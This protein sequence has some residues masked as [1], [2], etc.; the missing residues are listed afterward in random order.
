ML[1]QLFYRAEPARD[2]EPRLDELWNRVRTSYP[3]A[4]VRDADRALR[5]FAAHPSIRY[6][7]FLVCPRFSSRAVASAVF[8]LE[9]DCLRWVDVVWDHGHPGALNLLAFISGRLV[10]QIGA[11]HEELWLAGD[12]EAHPLLANVGFSQSTSSAPPFIAARSLVSELDAEEF[13][14]ST[15][16]TLSDAGGLSQ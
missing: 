2:W 5:R 9:D 8:A 6:D 7:R 16:L 1:A 4:V 15:Y 11:E 3:V 14:A 10:G 12:D 13:V